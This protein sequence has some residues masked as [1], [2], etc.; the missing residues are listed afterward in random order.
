M[1]LTIFICNSFYTVI[2]AIEV[3]S[4][5]GGEG[6]T[7]GNLLLYG[8]PVCDQGWNDQAATVACRMLN[9]SFTSGKATKN[10]QFGNVTS[11]F[12][13][14]E[15]TCVGTEQSLLDCTGDCNTNCGQAE[16]AGVICQVLTTTS[17]T[18]KRTTTSTPTT[19]TT[20]TATTS[21]TS[22][23]TPTTTTTTT[24]TTS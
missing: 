1:L 3:I 20:T 16:A 8:S 2:S 4:L 13:F 9:S 15:V 23:P 10:S 7:E 21:T 12:I 6:R 18:T 5:T 22:T 11:S 19:T 24:A 14:T 17:T